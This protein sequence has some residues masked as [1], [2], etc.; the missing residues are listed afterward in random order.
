MSLSFRLQLPADAA[1]RPLAGDAASRLAEIVGG[2]AADGAAFAA[3]VDDALS[4]IGTGAGMVDL[5]F[6][7][8]AGALEAVVE[9]GGQSRV[10][11]GTVSDPKG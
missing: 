2:T 11:R 5:A 6:R 9:R 8:E 4:A 7:S 1:F 10:L 3:A